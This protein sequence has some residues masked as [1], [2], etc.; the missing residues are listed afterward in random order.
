M[1]S[2]QSLSA[3]F[4]GTFLFENISFLVNSGDRVGLVGRN[5]AGKSTLMRIISGQQKPEGGKIAMPKEATLGYLSQD[6]VAGSDKTVREEVASSRQEI[7]H[8]QKLMKSIEEELAV[9]T[10][11]E[12]DEY[13]QLL[14]DITYAAERFSMLDGYNSDADLEKILIGLGFERSD[15][16]RPCNEFS[17]GWRMRIELARLLINRPDVLLLDEPTNHLDIESIQ[18]LEGFM[19]S[20]PGAVIL[21]SHDKTL[22]DKMTNRTIEITSGKIYD[23]KTNYSN[24]LIEREERKAMQLNAKKNQDKYIEHTQELINK[25]RAKK[26]KASFAQSLIKKLD[27]LDRVEVDESDSRKLAFKFP[28]SPRA[29][30]VVLEVN[31][32]AKKYGEKVILKDVSF[33]VERNE[34]IALAGK[35]GEGKSTLVKIIAG[36][37]DYEGKIEPGY[38][39]DIGYFAQNQAE[40]LDGERTVLETIDDAAV[41]D[42]R[43]DIRALLGMF[44]FSGDD[45]FKKVKVLSG[46][47]K[48]RLALC[49]LLLHPYNVLVLDE[50]TNHLDIASKEVLKRALNNY[51]GTM[52]LVSHDRDF[53]D[54]LT[55]KTLYFRK[56]NVKEILGGIS[57]FLDK[58]K[59]QTLFLESVEGVLQTEKNKKQKQEVP[60]QTQRQ[61]QEKNQKKLEQQLKKT[62]DSIAH[63]E[64]EIAETEKQLSDPNI[65]EDAKKTAQLISLHQKQQEQ[66]RQLMTEWEKISE[67]IE[68]SAS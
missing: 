49:K 67:M 66:H 34:K 2:V 26:N 36:V 56:G 8:L 9:R 32:V 30:R 39:V 40:L 27:K 62:E 21:V 54:G 28:P 20:Y 51:D 59:S 58:L 63:C 18:W 3:G 61:E 33:M 25:F 4:G 35:N 57:E 41:G 22:L 31:H 13:H 14:E 10:D 11:Y 12:S 1:L 7:D 37:L 55:Q 50:P 60:N 64:K 17:G 68:G 29:G 42:I 52:L 5:G 48:N 23:F 19:S 65:L 16:D 24:Y 45:V 47:E 6:I 43:K 44:M 53:L 38:N 15:F 46:G